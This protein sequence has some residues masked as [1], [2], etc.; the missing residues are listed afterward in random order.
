MLNRLLNIK[1]KKVLVIGDSM[2]DYYISVEACK[3]STE[4]S[5]LIYEEKGSYYSLGGAANVAS[6]IASYGVEVDLL[7]VIGNDYEKNIFLDLL[8]KSGIRTKYTIS[9][10]SY[11]T[12]VKTRL[13][14]SDN[15]QIVRFDKEKREIQNFSFVLDKFKEIKLNSYDF[16]IISDYRKGLITNEFFNKIIEFA[17]ERNIRVLC[18]PKDNK[19]NYRNMWLMKPNVKEMKNLI[20]SY[21]DNFFQK[22]IEY[23]VNHNINNIV[24]TRGENGLVLFDE[25][26]NIIKFKTNPIDVFDVTGAG[27][28]ILSYLTVG[29]LA[30]LT[31]NDSMNLANIAAEVKVSKYRTK[32]IT[33]E[34][35]IDKLLQFS[36]NKLIPR[37]DIVYIVNIFKNIGKTIIFTNG[38][39]DILHAGHIHLL[40]QCKSHGDILILGL[41]SDDSIKKLKGRQRPINKLADR[42]KVLSSI[43]YI[44]Y[45][46]VFN[47]DTPLDLINEIQPDVLVK[48][49]DYY[50][51]KVVGSDIVKSNNGKVVLIDLLEGRSTSRIIYSSLRESDR[52]N[53]II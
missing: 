42:I 40:S 32:V 45:I 53:E 51:K 47:E 12:I 18:D 30:G 14:S 19:V 48:G 36:T 49:M 10:S 2:L 4:Y 34:D 21:D 15:K 26:N 24:L 44:N 5:G 11:Q 7:S 50:E 37:K 33:I 23:K 8:I 28:I 13:Y 52:T 38:C 17:E 25:Y 43:S 39:F 41:N 27:D 46:V 35:I 29:L 1:N 20:S 9:E 6:S 3:I 22:I 16:I 31:L